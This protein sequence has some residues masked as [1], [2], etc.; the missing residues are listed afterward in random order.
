VIES[1]ADHSAALEQIAEL[2]ASDPEAGSDSE[3]LLKTFAVLVRD[4][5][6]ARYPIVDP[7]PI[8]AIKF[9]M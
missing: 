8:E 4:Y 1:E 6:S 2:M 9:R 3:R 7:D 5:E